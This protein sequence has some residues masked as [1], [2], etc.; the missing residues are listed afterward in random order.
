MLLLNGGQKIWSRE[1]VGMCQDIS[2]GVRNKKHKKVV[3][4][5]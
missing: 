2:K 3:L 4:K 5:R 1:D